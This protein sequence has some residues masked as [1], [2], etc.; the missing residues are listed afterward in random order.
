MIFN[1]GTASPLGTH[2]WMMQVT[3]IDSPNI[4]NFLHNVNLNKLLGCAIGGYH[5]SIF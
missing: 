3:I 2:P 4:P 5:F 1:N